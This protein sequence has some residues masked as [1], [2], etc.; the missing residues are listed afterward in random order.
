M[1]KISLVI[2]SLLFCQFAFGELSM[3][4][5]RFNQMSNKQIDSLLVEIQQKSLTVTQRINLFSEMFLDMDYDSKCTGDGPYAIYEPYPLVNFRQTNCMVLCEHVLALS[6]SDN[7]SHFFNNL[8]NIRYQ[9]GVI[10]IKTRNHY[11][12][13]DWLPENSWLLDDVTKSVGGKFAK[14]ITRTISHKQFFKSKG[15]TN[16]DYI[17]PDRTIDAWFIPFSKLKVLKD[18][19]QPGDIISI[20]FSKKKNIFSAHM[21]IVAQKDDQLVIRESSNSKMTTFDTLFE[22]WVDQ[23]TD[24]GKYCGVTIF[25]VKPEINQPGKIILPQNIKYI[26]KAK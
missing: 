13:A 21:T 14:P 23:K 17:K 15:L 24:L 6:I 8:Q 22:K 10:G 7:W 20:I 12:V 25:R 11:T 3:N 26:K 19:I 18:L 4:S 9:N 16:F 5:S 1:K 2:L